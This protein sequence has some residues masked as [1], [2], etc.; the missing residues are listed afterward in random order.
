MLALTCTRPRDR[1]RLQ[2]VCQ[3]NRVAGDDRQSCRKFLPQ[4][5][6]IYI[7]APGRTPHHVGR[8]SL[9]C[10][11]QLCRHH[12]DSCKYKKSLRW[13]EAIFDKIS[14][15]KIS[16]PYAGRPAGGTPCRSPDQVRRVFSQIRPDNRANHPQRTYPIIPAPQTG[17]W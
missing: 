9:P 2:I 14:R 4:Q 15:L 5:V 1:T 6:H 17:Q 8:L 12:Q 10:L 13:P 7:F 3:M 16:L 11:F